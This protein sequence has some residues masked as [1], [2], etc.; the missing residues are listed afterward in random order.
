[1]VDV[2]VDVLQNSSSGHRSGRVELLPKNRFVIPLALQYRVYIVMVCSFFFR[3]AKE[4]T[5]CVE[6]TQ[7]LSTFDHRCFKALLESGWNV[8]WAIKRRFVLLLRYSV[9]VA[10][11]GLVTF[12]ACIP[13][14]CLFVFFFHVL[15]EAAR[16]SMMVGL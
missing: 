7:Q 8:E 16:S 3:F 14:I 10:S 6:D 12:C 13:V 2:T 4:L 1:M 5:F 11:G 9:H 15:F